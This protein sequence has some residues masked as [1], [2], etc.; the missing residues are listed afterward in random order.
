MKIRVMQELGIDGVCIDVLDN[1]MGI[2]FIDVRRIVISSINSDFVT[3]RFCRTRSTLGSLTIPNVE[4][5]DLFAKLRQT[6]TYIKGK[7]KIEGKAKIE[8]E[9]AMKGVLSN[10]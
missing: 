1:K 5:A 8:G 7:V 4:A 6:R 2:L 9:L 10:A 3:L